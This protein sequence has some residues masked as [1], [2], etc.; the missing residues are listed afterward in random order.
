[1]IMTMSM[2]MSERIIY[3]LQYKEK[4]LNELT[5]F[6]SSYSHDWKCREPFKDHDIKA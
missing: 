3:M 1:M 5:I 6:M 4:E 2:L